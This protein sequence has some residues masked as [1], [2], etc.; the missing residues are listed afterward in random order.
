MFERLI[1]GA[2]VALIGFAF[3]PA[4][5]EL[6]KQS[7]SEQIASVHHELADAIEQISYQEKLL[8]LSDQLEGMQ[9]QQNEM[10]DSL[11]KIAQSLKKTDSA[12]FVSK[13]DLDAALESAKETIVKTKD[14]SPVCDCDCNCLAKLGELEKRIEALESELSRKTSTGMKTGSG[15]TGTSTSTTTVQYSQPAVGYVV[16]TGGSTGSY[17]Q[18]TYTQA[19]MALELP[20]QTRT[21]KVVEPRSRRQVTFAEVP[22][23]SDVDLTVQSAPQQCYT[24]SNG[25]RVCPQ[26]SAPS[27]SRPTVGSRLGLG[28]RLFGR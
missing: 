27:V 16:Q 6:P 4:T 1:T 10:L 9:Y 17:T 3:I 21:V 13:T 14:F 12:K 11:D 5:E 2:L 19:P 24:D 20:N 28:S 8:Q 26:T 15:S 25:N 7:T 23:T 18:S 22:E